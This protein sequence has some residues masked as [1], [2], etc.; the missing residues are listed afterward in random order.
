MPHKIRIFSR[1]TNPA[2]TYQTYTPED[3]RSIGQTLS[4]ERARLEEVRRLSVEE[5]SR[6]YDEMISRNRV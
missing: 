1:T 5:A 6:L 4:A 2:Q 3:L